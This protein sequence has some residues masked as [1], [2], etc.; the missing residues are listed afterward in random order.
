MLRKFILHSNMHFFSHRTDLGRNALR[1]GA[2]LP[3]SE[4]NIVGI[5]CVR[6]GGWMDG[7]MVGYIHI[8]VRKGASDPPGRSEWD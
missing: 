7:W 8:S 5:A 6:M 3:H 2:A 1:I 4:P